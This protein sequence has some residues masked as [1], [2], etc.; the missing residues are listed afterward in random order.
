M[1]MEERDVHRPVAQKEQDRDDDQ[2][3]CQQALECHQ[4][5]A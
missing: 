4:K 3:R 1:P 5:S 2:G